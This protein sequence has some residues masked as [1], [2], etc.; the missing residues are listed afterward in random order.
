[1]DVPVPAAHRA[2]RGPEVGAG[3]V[4]EGLSESEAAGLVADEGAEDVSLFAGER[5]SEGR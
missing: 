5:A 3:R 4:D 2:G 1:M